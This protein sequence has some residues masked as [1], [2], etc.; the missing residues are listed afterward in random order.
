MPAVAKQT[1][2]GDEVISEIYRLSGGIPRLINTIC[3]NALLTGYAADSTTIGLDIVEEVASDL[4]LSHLPRFP[5]RAI[6]GGSFRNWTHTAGNLTEIPSR[7]DD[8]PSEKVRINSESFDLFVQF[9]DK[10]R[11][12]AK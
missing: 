5:V 12:N 2:F 10:L 4:E 7:K 1:V 8:L 3:D 6:A 11:E 9:V